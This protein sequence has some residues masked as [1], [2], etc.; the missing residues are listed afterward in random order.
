MVI[1]VLARGYFAIKDMMRGRYTKDIKGVRFG[2]TKRMERSTHD[3]Q[4][5]NTTK[6]ESPI[7][8]KRI[9]KIGSSFNGEYF[10]IT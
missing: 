7:F 8:H 10:V 3:V 5:T 9:C 6:I 1:T 4:R 2:V